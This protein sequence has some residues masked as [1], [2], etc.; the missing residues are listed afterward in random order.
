MVQGRWLRARPP[1]TGLH[2]QGFVGYAVGHESEAGK[3][4][5]AGALPAGCQMA[6]R[7][8]W[9]ASTGWAAMARMRY[10][11][12]I[13]KTLE[14]SGSLW[15]ELEGHRPQDPL[16]QAG[17]DRGQV[18][19]TD[20]P[21]THG[22]ASCG[23]PILSPIT[24]Y[25]IYRRKAAAF[26]TAMVAHPHSQGRQAASPVTALRCI[27]VVINVLC[28]HGNYIRNSHHNPRHGSDLIWYHG[29]ASNHSTISDRAVPR[30]LSPSFS[31]WQSEC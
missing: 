18:C 30:S 27:S 28:T 1:P 9:Q 7:V 17:A 15:R 6:R 25:N 29:W 22:N 8:S 20:S 4:V 3:P 2:S 12:A 19:N 5:A 31:S 24:I 21:I 10:T 11:A 13:A 23:T 16:A 14:G 26:T